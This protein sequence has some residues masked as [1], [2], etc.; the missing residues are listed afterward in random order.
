MLLQKAIYLNLKSTFNI[1]KRF[2]IHKSYSEEK[3]NYLQ[4][5]DEDISTKVKVKRRISVEQKGTNTV[6]KL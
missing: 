4:V 5:A 3:G 6:E 2:Y 1:P